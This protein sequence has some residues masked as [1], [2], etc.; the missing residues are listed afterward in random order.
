MALIDLYK[1]YMYGNA[2]QDMGFA[3]GERL[4][5]GT[6]GLFG[7]GGQAN[8]QGLLTA[9]TDPSESNIGKFY[10]NPFIMGGLRAIQAGGM[11]QSASTALPGAAI[12]A[13][14][15]VSLAEKYKDLM[16][17]RKAKKEIQTSSAFTPA[18]KLAVRAGIK[19]PQNNAT[20]KQKEYASYMNVMK[21]GTAIEK[22]AAGIIYGGNRELS[23][24]E[25]INKA[26][27]NLTK[28]AT[29][30]PSS[31]ELNE[32][33]IPQLSET[34]DNIQN[35]Y[36]VSSIQNTSSS[37]IPTGFQGTAEQFK[38][39]RND[40]KNKEFTDK[41]LIDFFNKKYGSR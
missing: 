4:T 26:V 24:T 29:L 21:N 5:G 37:Q 8:D 18:Q 20:A 16:D 35:K 14:Q 19:L 28:D 7:Q 27:L 3:G 23:K 2:P 41:Q 25:F 33:I 9:V 17:K 32:T 39:L 13:L 11:G 36:N 30:K 12:G 6:Q 38:T 40:P 31:K 15:D 1:R 34:Y 10:S 22:Q